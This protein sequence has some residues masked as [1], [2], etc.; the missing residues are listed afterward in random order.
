MPCAQRSWLANLSVVAYLLNFGVLCYG[1]QA[2]PGPVQF[3]DRRQE[4]FLKALPEYHVVAPVRVDARGHFLSYGLHHPVTDNSRRKRDVDGSEDR[5]YYRISHE[6]KD[7]FFNLSVNQG[8]LS[9][10]YILERRYG[11]LSHVKMVASSAPPC[12][13]RGTVLQQGASIGTAALSACQGLTGFFHLPHGDFFIEPVKKHPLAE[14]E[15]HPHIIYR[16]PRQRPPEKEEPTCGLKDGLATSQKP[17]RQRE[18]WER[19]QWPRRSLSRRSISKERWVETLV[20]ADT[21]MIE[22]HGSDSVESYILTIMNMVTGLFHN[23]SIGNAI[24]I[25]VVRLILLEEEEQGLKITHHAEKTLSSFCKWQKSINPKSDLNPAHH[26]VAVLLTRKDICAG[27]NRPCETLGLSHLSGMCQPH[28][29]CNINEDSGLPLAFTIAHELGHSFGIQHDGKENDCEPEGRH[30]YLMSRQLQYNPSPLTWSKCSKEYITRFLDRGWGF[31]LDDI[32][33][34]KGLKSKVIAP[35]VIYDVHHQCQLQYGPNATFCQEVENVCQTLWCSV[36]GF[37]R[38]KLDAAADGTRCG[39]KKWCMA[40]KCITVGKKPESI[41]GGWGRWSPWSHCSRTCGAGAQSAERLCNNP[42]PKFGGKYCTGERKRYRLCNVHPCRPDVPTFRQMQ[43]SE[44]DT[45]PYKNELYHWF[46][47]FN[48]AHPCELY[49]RPIDG[50]FSEKML[51]AVID[52]TPCFEGGNSRNVCINGIC[53]V[54]GCDYEIGSNATEDRCGVCLGDGSACQTVKKMF[55][56]KEG[57]GYVDIGLIPKGARDI[58]VMELEGAGNFLAIRSEDP[59]KYY[60]NGGFIIQWN[61]NYKLAGTTFQYDR[62]GDLEKLMATGPTN[63]SVWI[64]L[65]FQVTN[66]G[67]KYEYTIRKDGLDN[68]VGKLVYFWQYGHWTECSVTCGTGVRRQTAHCVK[69]GHG[70]V[71]ATFCDP[72]TQPNGRQKKCYE[73][74][75]PPRWWAGEWEA[76]SATCG[77]HGEKKRTVL[78]VQTTGSDE[79]ALPAKDCQHLLKPKTLISCNRDILCPSDWTVGNWSECSV[80]CGGGVRIRSVTCAKNHDEPCDVTRKPNSRAL[81]GLQQCPSS[82]RVLKPHKDPIPSGRNLPTSEPDPPQPIPPT[83][84]SPRMLSTSTVPESMSTSTGAV[85]SPS[86]TTAAGQGDTD[87]KWWQNSSHQTEP[88][89]HYVLSTGS[90]SQ[91]IPTSW[92]LSS[93]PN[94]GNVPNSH[95][96]PISEGDFFTT[97]VS[98][99][100]LPSSGK[101]VT[102]QVTP[103]Y[104]T[105]TKE[106]GIEIH[107]GSGEDSEQSEIKNENNSVTWTEIRV[108]GKDASVVRSTEIPLGPPPT[109][110]LRGASLWPPFSTVMEDLLPSHRPATLKNGTPGAEVITEKPANTPFPLGGDHQ[111]APT[112]HSVRHNPPE[113]PGS[114][115]LMQGSGPVLTKEDATSLI[116]EG[117]LLNASDY[118]ELSTGG[119]PAYWIAGNWSEC[120]TSCGLGAYWRS[121]ECSTGRDSDCAA[122]QKPDPAKRCHLRP[123]ASWRVGNWSKCSRNCSGGF[124]IREIQCVDSLD[125]R[126]LRPFHCQFLAGIRPPLSMSCNVEPCEEWQVEPWNQCSRSCGGGVQER[127]VTCPGGLCDWKK[128]PTPTAPCNSHPCCHWVAGNWDLCT[129]SCGGGFQKR[130]VHCVSSEDNTTEDQCLCDHEPKPPEFRKCGQEA[131]KKRDDL[132]CSKDNLSTSFC[133]TLKTMKKCSVPT[134]RAQCCLTCSQTHVVH[135]RRPRKPQSLKN[136]KAF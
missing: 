32:P 39:E 27:V 6:E 135:T 119:S 92:S 53:K 50:Q 12:H 41:P 114:V 10:S 16:K 3:P 82:R 34:K 94:E 55:K 83:P 127:A 13:L 90:T 93:Q 113:L 30:P 20:V 77:P 74:D 79:Q 122:V 98:G 54:V 66:P 60:L 4:H 49:C 87:A 43:C 103:F 47:V 29:S 111:P 101:P 19:S 8:F 7:L 70:M 120:S 134:V 132:L 42:E 104:N 59:Q 115:N 28:R 36:K 97:T 128:R 5:V 15:Y 33:Q 69:K 91:P 61:G 56:Q 52:G 102:W 72:E 26:D 63:E 85:S 116:A 106:P 44:F 58:R 108:A 118:K 21:K 51:D 89:S 40:G 2:Q 133:Q 76:C 45:V 68:D 23:P 73:K 121:V 99:S 37:C 65:L 95:P 129:A 17:E 67:I 109:P 62:K 84:S 18:E 25:V 100:D 88:G 14:G 35:G 22:Y 75:C 46:P 1:S 130:T 125:H 38:S 64:Q 126:S 131:C 86:P 123:C 57:S 96:G 11:N 24:H 48:P 71:K 110:Y 112:E 105:L 31:C 124:Q 136:P 117:F 78:C 81:C 9:K 107:S 80:S